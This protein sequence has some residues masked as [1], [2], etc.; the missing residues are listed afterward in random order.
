VSSPPCCDHHLTGGDWRPPGH[1]RSTRLRVIDDDVQLQNFGVH[2][3]WRK[4][5]VRDALHQ[6]VS[7]AMLC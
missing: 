7:T 4:A 2:T 1:P 6:V 5:K 3:A